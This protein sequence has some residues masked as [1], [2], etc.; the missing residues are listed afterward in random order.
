[1]EIRKTDIHAKK[2]LQQSYYHEIWTVA[3][4]HQQDKIEWSKL[5]NQLRK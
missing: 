2:P 4:T 5:S 3:C 1:M